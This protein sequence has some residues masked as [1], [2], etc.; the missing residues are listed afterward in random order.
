MAWTAPATVVTGERMLASF[1]NTQVRDNTAYLLNPAHDE[2]Q[3]LNLSTTSVTYVDTGLE[4]TIITNGGLVTVHFDG[5]FWLSV[6]TGLVN[7]RMT[8][9]GSEKRN[10]EFLV[11]DTDEIG[12]VSMIWLEEMTAASHTIKIQYRCESGDTLNMNDNYLFIKEA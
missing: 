11:L 5:L 6:G 1:W 12:S 2:I 3:L 7:F 9:D 8:V 4:V 10:K